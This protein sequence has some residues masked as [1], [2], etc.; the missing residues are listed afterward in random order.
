[1]AGA[2]FVPQPVALSSAQ[3]EFNAAAMAYTAVRHVV[4]VYHEMRGVDP[5]QPLTVPFY[6]DST[7]AISIMRN[8]HDNRG[9]RHIARRFF[10]VRQ[11]VHTGDVDPT[12]I[13]TAFNL[14]DTGTKNVEHTI[15][16][17]HRR[18]MHNRVD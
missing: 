10:V 6:I 2:S 15:S 3:A 11:A 18:V 16:T 13:D 1:M 17:R 5:D 7:S 9:T 14:A 4:H 12:K 8:D